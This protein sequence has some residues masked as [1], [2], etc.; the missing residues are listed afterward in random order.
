MHANSRKIR[1]FTLIELLVVIAIIGMLSSIVFASLN[2][3]RQKGRD[4]KRLAEI[5]ELRKSLEYYFSENGAYPPSATLTNGN[6]PNTS[7]SNSSNASWLGTQ[8]FP[9]AMSKYF[10][11]LPVDPI[12]SVGWAGGDTTFNYSYVSC[13]G[14]QYMIIYKLERP[15]GQISPGAQC[16]ASF[17]NYGYSNVPNQVSKGLITI[18]P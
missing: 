1:G 8:P 13:G 16:G 5:S 3:A 18:G 7:W 4:A 10:S 14:N 2:T 11:K 6:Y 15:I 9:S 17:Y 12:N